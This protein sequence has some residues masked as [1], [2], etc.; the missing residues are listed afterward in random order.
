MLGNRML[1]FHHYVL[2]QDISQTNI[3]LVPINDKIQDWYSFLIDLDYTIYIA[4][5]TLLCKSTGASHK[6]KT[7]SYITINILYDNHSLYFYQYDVEFFLYILLW[8]CIY[9][10][11]QRGY[12]FIANTLDYSNSILVTK[13]LTIE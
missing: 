11:N 3:L 10:G 2:H 4:A 5:D 9:N 1:Y 12:I 8:F 6:I 13:T 7:L